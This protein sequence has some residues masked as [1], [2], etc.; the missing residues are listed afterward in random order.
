MIR[1]ELGRG[2]FL[3]PVVAR[4][5]RAAGAQAHLDVTRLAL[6]AAA[7]EAV[8]GAW[9]AATSDDLLR[10]A[11][12]R[13]P[14]SLSIGFAFA[15]RAAAQDA[16][17]AGGLPAGGNQDGRLCARLR[18]GPVAPGWEVLLVVS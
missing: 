4:A 17:D 6:A 9:A 8:A 16:W 7:A 3:L 11:I 5:V 2:P 12:D 10:V 13:G 1:L 14:G 15:D 18:A